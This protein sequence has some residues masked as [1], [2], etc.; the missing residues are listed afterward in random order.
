[1]IHPNIWDL[2]DRI[3]R[4]KKQ[5]FV[6]YYDFKIWEKG[7]SFILLGPRGIGKT[8]ILIQYLS[9][10]QKLRNERE[11]LYLQADHI[12]LGESGI[13]DLA[14]DFYN[15]GGKILAIDEI[16]KQLNWSKELKSIL[17]TFPK[18]KLL[19]SGSSVLDLLKG[20]H[21]ISRRI[22][23]SHLRGFSLREFI[24]FKMGLDFPAITLLEL[25]SKHRKFALEILSKIKDVPILSLF[26]DYLRRGYYPFSLETTDL[27]LFQSSL[28]NT[29][30]LTVEID[31]PGAYP[32]MTEV[33]VQKILKLLKFLARNV[34]YEP[35][36]KK[37]K[38]LLYS[39]A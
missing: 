14:E 34:P 32:E 23:I 37:L 12:I 30:R 22:H 10:Q 31:V 9:M 35:D 17:D 2:S 24:N 15:Q 29:A 19:C 36:L 4:E 3:I 8:T 25:L 1:M 18:L 21:D 11:V 6:R 20:T 5:N 13:Y 39:C 16:H 27:S 33:S 28:E 7:K 26:N 38:E